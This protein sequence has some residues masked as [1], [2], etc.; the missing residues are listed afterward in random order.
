[1]SKSALLK[2]NGGPNS[3][4]TEL[5]ALAL[6][7]SIFICNSHY[8]FQDKFFLYLVIDLVQGGDMKYNLLVSSH[9]RF[10]E[11][12]SKFYIAQLIIA[13]DICHQSNILHRFSI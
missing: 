10:T 5:R 2:R 13:L 11:S 9:G 4:L 8:A 7:E 3:A 12:L 6:L 1:M